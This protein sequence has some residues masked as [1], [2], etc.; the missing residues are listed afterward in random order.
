MGLTT[1][2]PRWAALISLLL[3]LSA[4]GGAEEGPFTRD[5]QAPGPADLE[6]PTL[7]WSDY[8]ALV[9]RTSSAGQV[10]VVNFWAT[11]CG[12]CVEEFPELMQLQRDYWGRGV[13]VATI[14]M[15]ELDVLEEEVKPFLFEQR[16][17]G[18]RYFM[19]TDWPQD[20]QSRLSESWW[21]GIPQ[22]FVYDPGGRLTASLTGRQTYEQFQE[23]VE[24][25]LGTVTTR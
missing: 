5:F 24:S 6:V 3:I 20:F 7:A 4:C 25:A 1:E 21:G 23:A 22:T 9:D 15:D 11:W 14:S 17:V 8:Q 2:R 10:L 13:R 12:P 19:G 16:A 18:A